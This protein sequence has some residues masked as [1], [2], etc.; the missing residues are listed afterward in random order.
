MDRAGASAPTGRVDAVRERSAKPDVLPKDFENSR[1]N[2]GGNSGA[3]NINN[4]SKQ[5][6]VCVI[7]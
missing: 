6:N 4:N 5:S 3:R 1:E 2:S 7:L